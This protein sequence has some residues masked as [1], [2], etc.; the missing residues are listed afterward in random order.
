MAV[1]AEKSENQ[2]QSWVNPPFSRNKS[3]GF[4]ERFQWICSTIS[5]DLLNDSIGMASQGCRFS[6]Q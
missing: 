2:G 1:T 5:M 4:V 3:I 6:C